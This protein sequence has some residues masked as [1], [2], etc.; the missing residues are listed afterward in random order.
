MTPE[1]LNARLTYQWQPEIRV[2]LVDAKRNEYEFPTVGIW[3]AEQGDSIFESDG[4]LSRSQ[5]RALWRWLG[6]TDKPPTKLWIALN[7]EDVMRAFPAEPK[8]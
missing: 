6:R 1:H 3:L 4:V 5:C 8:Q 2:M 7:R